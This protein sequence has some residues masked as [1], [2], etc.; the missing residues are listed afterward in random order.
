M[1]ETAKGFVGWEQRELTILALVVR[2]AIF[3]CDL[4]V[5]VLFCRLFE[6]F[7]AFADGSR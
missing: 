7:E 2:V 4:F 3:F 5:V 6:F 1:I